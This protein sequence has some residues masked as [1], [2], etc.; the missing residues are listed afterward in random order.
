M[1]RILGGDASAA[2]VRTA[3]GAHHY[4]LIALELAVPPGSYN[5]GLVRFGTGEETNEKD[6]PHHLVLERSYVHGDP[7]TGGKGSYGHRHKDA[8]D[9]VGRPDRF[10]AR[11]APR[12]GPGG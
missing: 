7:K 9:H 10:H 6:F 4:R 11:P 12:V 3:A 8:E 2:A 1:A 5:T